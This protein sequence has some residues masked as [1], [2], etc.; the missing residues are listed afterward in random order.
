VKAC[1]KGSKEVAFISPKTPSAPGSYVLR[2]AEYNSKGTFLW[3][4]DLNVLNADFDADSGSS[5]FTSPPEIYFTKS[6]YEKMDLYQISAY[7]SQGKHRNACLIIRDFLSDFRGTFLTK[8]DLIYRISQGGL[9]TDL[10]SYIGGFAIPIA[11]KCAPWM[12][13]YVVIND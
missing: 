10:R 13:D 6:A 1:T 5:Y 9:G 3:D 2:I 7:T 11:I 4:Q 12:A 8:K